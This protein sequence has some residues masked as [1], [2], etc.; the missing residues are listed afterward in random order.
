MAAQS[1][2]F[3]EAA[4]SEKQASESEAEITED[5]EEADE[6]NVRIQGSCAERVREILDIMIQETE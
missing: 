5:K 1:L 4:N 6:T 3:E 2:K